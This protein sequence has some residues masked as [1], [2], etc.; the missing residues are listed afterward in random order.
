[1]HK[2]Y[3]N[4]FLFFLLLTWF[5]GTIN[6]TKPEI[7]PWFIRQINIDISDYFN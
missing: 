5:I 7:V 6:I 2:S 1:M 3:S 4:N